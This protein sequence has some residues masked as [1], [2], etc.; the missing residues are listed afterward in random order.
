MV[1]PDHV[2]AV[3]THEASIHLQAAP[4]RVALVVP[5]RLVPVDADPGLEALRVA[6]A[7]DAGPRR[8]SGRARAPG[9]RAVC[10]GSRGASRGAAEAARAARRAAPVP[11][12]GRA[13][14]ATAAAA[15]AP[16]NTRRSRRAHGGRRHCSRSGHPMGVRVCVMTARDRRNGDGERQRD[17]LRD[18]RSHR[19]SFS[20]CA[21][22]GRVRG[23]TDAGRPQRAAVVPL[24]FVRVAPLVL[25][26]RPHG[27]SCGAVRLVAG[28]LVGPLGRRPFVRTTI[29]MAHLAVLFQDDHP[30][31]TRRQPR[32]S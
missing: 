6:P 22:Q 9:S 1:A 8:G 11:R 15:C 17:K 28:L 25:P 7:A 18:E 14:S 23:G 3:G 26:L 29:L 24:G 16:G 20:S 30:P 27:A 2:A 5:G 12:C 32:Y 4:V 31:G 19:S 10:A 13:R 21:P